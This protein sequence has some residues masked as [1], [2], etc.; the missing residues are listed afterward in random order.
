M[1]RTCDTILYAIE[2]RIL[3]GGEIAPGIRL[4]GQDDFPAV[5]AMTYEDGDS[6]K[7]IWGFIG[8]PTGSAF[9]LLLEEEGRVIG[10]MSL[11][12]TAIGGEIEPLLE[13]I[14]IDAGHRHRGQ[15]QR[16]GTGFLSVIEAA[17]HEVNADI[18]GAADCFSSHIEGDFNDDGQE[19]ADFLSNEITR[20]VGDILDGPD[21]PSETI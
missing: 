2:Q 6:V 21:D 11:E 15:A 5:N 20:I 4:A 17:L 3:A 12:L 10:Q 8:D 16:L 9:T 13:C 14:F 1:D 7:N 18:P 19:F